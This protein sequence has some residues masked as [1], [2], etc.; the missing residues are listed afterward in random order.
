MLF[1]RTQ[2]EKRWNVKPTYVGNEDKFR[3]S[4]LTGYNQSLF[5][6][7]FKCLKMGSWEVAIGHFIAFPLIFCLSYSIFQPMSIGANY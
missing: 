3:V 5:C 6:F 7:S 2:D 1:S 4:L